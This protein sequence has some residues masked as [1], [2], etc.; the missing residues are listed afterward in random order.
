MNFYEKLGKKWDEGKFVCVGLDPVSSKIPESVFGREWNVTEAVITFCEE[1]IYA[2]RP[3]ACAYKPNSAFFEALG[4]AGLKALQEVVAYAN[5][6]TDAVTICDS[7]RGD[8]GN[9][10]NGYV[11]SVFDI[12]NADAITINPYLGK[13]ANQ[14]F[15]AREDKGI[16]VL[17]RTSNKGAGEF[18]DL[19]VNDEPFYLRVARNVAN[20]W[21]VNKNCALVVGATCPEELKQVRKV[22]GDIPILIPGIGAQGGDLEAS[23]RNGMDGNGQGFI[24]NSS[25]GIIYADNSEDFAKAAGEAAK[26]LNDEINLYRR[27]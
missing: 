23:V 15:L 26:A 17:C 16:I 19:W 18:Q 21:N 27:G 5:R 1:I 22:A 3:Y 14:P 24:I 2:T 20:V 10:N 7:K 11:E 6:Y 12:M 4:E 13:E 9:T 8:I 25:R